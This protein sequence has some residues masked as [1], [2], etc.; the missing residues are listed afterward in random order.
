MPLGSIT[1]LQP[2]TSTSA[3]ADQTNR[4]QP[5]RSYFLTPIWL[6]TICSPFS[7]R[8]RAHK[9]PKLR[10]AIK[11]LK[12]AKLDPAFAKADLGFIIK[13]GRNVTTLADAFRLH[14]VA[15]TNPSAH[16]DITLLADQIRHECYKQF[17]Q[18]G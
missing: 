4:F 1:T 17:C 3:L 9:Q 10:E 13:S 12:L 11:S 2:I 16:F 15:L 14:K 7:G 6:K 8:V 5:K 18:R